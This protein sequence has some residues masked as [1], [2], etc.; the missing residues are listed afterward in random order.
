MF[1]FPKCN[2]F[3]YLQKHS[4]INGLLRIP[5]NKLFSTVFG[6]S[7]IQLLSACDVWLFQMLHAWLTQHEVSVSNQIEAFCIHLFCFLLVCGKPLVTLWTNL[8]VVSSITFGVC[9][10]FGLTVFIFLPSLVFFNLFIRR[11]IWVFKRFFFWI[12][13]FLASFCSVL[14]WRH[15]WHHSVTHSRIFIIIISSQENYHFFCNMCV[16]NS[17]FY[18]LLK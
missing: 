10:V 13:Y 8:R 17:R 15:I 4:N 1:L 12:K 16:K 6:W 9:A 3:A 5:E 18:R 11:Y 2:N 14:L 7:C